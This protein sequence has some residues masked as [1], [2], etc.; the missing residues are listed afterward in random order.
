MEWAS[1]M[2]LHC[3]AQR[4]TQNVHWMSFFKVS[5]LCQTDGVWKQEPNFKEPNRTRH[6]PPTCPGVIYRFIQHTESTWEFPWRLAPE[7]WLQFENTNVLTRTYCR[8]PRLRCTSGSY[9]QYTLASP[10]G[11]ELD[12]QHRPNPAPS[13]LVSPST[14][15]HID[16]LVK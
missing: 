7:T 15:K 16:L 1:S 9:F 5:L 14:V 10:A 12:T 3:P 2:S 13:V 8:Q 4:L 6:S 11:A